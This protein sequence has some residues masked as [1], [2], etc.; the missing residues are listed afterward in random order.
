MPACYL[1]NIVKNLIAE[2]IKTNAAA[3][4]EIATEHFWRV[5][6]VPGQLDYD[7]VISKVYK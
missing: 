1:K 5:R 7:P 3:H 6:A 2:D 4:C